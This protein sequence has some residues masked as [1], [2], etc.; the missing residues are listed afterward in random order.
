MATNVEK[1][2]VFKPVK[3]CLKIDLMLHLASTDGLGKYIKG[4][5][6]HQNTSIQTNQINILYKTH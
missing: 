3:L 1:G 4:L 6:G 5:Q 2:T